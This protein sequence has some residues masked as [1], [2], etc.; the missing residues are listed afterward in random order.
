MDDKVIDVLLIEDDP[1]VLEM[2]SLKLTLDGYQVS[3]AEDGDQGIAKAVE[4]VPDIILLD[5]R[6]PGKDG[7]EVLEEL[8]QIKATAR[9]P[10]IIFSNYGEKELVNRGLELGAR[11][12]LVKAHTTPS[13][14]SAQLRGWLKK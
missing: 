11:A 3:T 13:S 1:A 4:L 5:I 6:M 10:V 2:Y 12:Y 8:R 9:I 7:F 14:L